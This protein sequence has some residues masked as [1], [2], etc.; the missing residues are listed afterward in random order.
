MLTAYNNAVP[1]A[2]ERILAMAEKQAAHRQNL[3]ERVVKGNIV[4][5]YLGSVFGFILGAIA[6]GG[7]IYLVG[8]GKSPKDAVGATVY[9]TANGT[10]QRGD[11]LSGGSY[12]SSNDFRVHFGL[13]DA[14]AVDAVEIRWPDGV[15]EKITP[16]SVDKIF[17][18]E[19]GKGI[20]GDNVAIK[21]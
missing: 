21:K 19:E 12:E 7:G 4:N 18:V 14:A 15:T 13:G 5:Q 16:S 10:K 8:S 11:V 6:I 1:N 17:V 2:A 9:V 3:E 20:V